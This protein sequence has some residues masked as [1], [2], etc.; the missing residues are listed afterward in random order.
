MQLPLAALESEFLRTPEADVPPSSVSCANEML[1]KFNIPKMTHYFSCC[2]SFLKCSVVFLKD[3][4]F[5]ADAFCDSNIWR[6]NLS[7]KCG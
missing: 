7:V 3:C 1:V 4:K 2:F 5:E 6:L